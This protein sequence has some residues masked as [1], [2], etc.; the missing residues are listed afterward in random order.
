[1]PKKPQQAAL[2][3]DFVPS[4]EQAMRALFETRWARWHHCKTFEAAVADPVTQRLLQLAVQH[5]A[6]H[7]LPAAR[8]AARG[9]L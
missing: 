4:Q 7:E 6:V 5:A 1:M 2:P 3:L 8:R 9:P